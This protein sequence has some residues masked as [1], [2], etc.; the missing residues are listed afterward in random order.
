MFVLL[1]MSTLFHDGL[2]TRADPGGTMMRA[3]SLD[4]DGDCCDV[5]AI[6]AWVVGPIEGS[7]APARMVAG[8]PGGIA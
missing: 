7:P 6:P 4:N 3:G 2:E 5:C 8:A 1:Q